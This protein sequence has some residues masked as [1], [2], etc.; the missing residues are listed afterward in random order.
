V[1]RFRS[2]VLSVIATVLT[3]SAG[4]AQTP[5]S[6]KSEIS[7]QF[8]ASA[9]KVL[10]LAEA[11][12]EQSYGWSP[13][14][15]VASVVSVYMH[16]SRYNYM[17]PEENLGVPS[18]MGAPA[19]GRWED[20]VTTKA[21]AVAIV[22]ASMDHVRSVIANMSDAELNAG[23][24]LYGRDVGKWSVLLQLV[25]HMNEHL[26]QSVAYARS[27]GVTPPWSM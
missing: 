12:P 7:Q 9:T 27:N 14:E 4:I 2:I 24:R 1:T 11:M 5:S 19:Y 16:I 8:E 6:F 25:A 22:A 13:M 15:G 26:G 23:T 21:E 17:Y 3:A 20:E 18:P 10:A